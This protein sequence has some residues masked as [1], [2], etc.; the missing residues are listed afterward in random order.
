MRLIATL[1]LLL[2]V[3]A[4]A[5]PSSILVKGGASPS[6]VLA[7]KAP[8]LTR[9]WRAIGWQQW[10]IAG[11]RL[12]ACDQLLKAGALAAEPDGIVTLAI[13]PNDSGYSVVVNG[14]Q[15][16]W[17]W[18]NGGPFVTGGCLDCDVD[19]PEGWD[20]DTSCAVPIGLID[21]GV[22]MDHPDLQDAIWTNPN[23][24]PANGVDDDLNGFVDDVH[25]WDFVN[26]DN[27][28]SDDNNH[29][30]HTAGIVGA[31]GDNLIGAVGVCWH[32]KIVP[33]KILG[34]SG[35][36]Y[37]S[38]VVAGFDYARGL[39]LKITS[40][41]W[42]M[43]FASQA[44]QDAIAACTAAGMLTVVAAGNNNRN[45]D[46]CPSECG[47]WPTVYPDVGIISVGAST[48]DDQRASFSNYGSQAVDLF[49][50]GYGIFST[51]ASSPFYQW[52]TGTS[53]ACPF[54]AAA[55]SAC[56]TLAP[57]AS[58][59]QVKGWIMSSVDVKADLAAIC[60]SGGR[61]NLYSAF[62]AAQTAGGGGQQETTGI[63]PGNP[64]SPLKGKVYDVQGRR[65][66]PA[67]RSGVTFSGGSKRVGIK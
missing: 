34:A 49:A 19:G 66:D 14:V 58:A 5:G 63:Q 47:S 30:T 23:E 51:W 33:I 64:A 41:S 65:V 4:Q 45:L 54:V 2:A 18:D 32:A 8:R 40:N 46:C 48:K 7:D 15:Y 3:P 21:T 9:E 27:D 11:D 1:L 67:A 59:S 26:G 57:N 53:M 22:M 39:G 35:A 60:A 25:G 52:A 13:A 20:V 38:D 12:A 62:R 17:W 24:T 16:V 31:Q 44:V 55:A 42:S 37:T 28:P 36:G 6:F 29:G 10:D 43:S 56:W 50:P 61:L